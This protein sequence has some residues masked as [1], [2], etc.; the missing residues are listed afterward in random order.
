LPTIAE[1]GL[2]GYDI[3][4]W[5]GVLVHGKTPKD[6]VAR[7]NQEILKALGD[8]E[9]QSR[10]TQLGADLVGNSSSE[11]DAFIRSQMKKWGE[12]IKQAGIEQS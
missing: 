7:W 4:E 1:S 8:P 9:M 11:F 5:W 10:L 6:L 12:V 2:P 3:G